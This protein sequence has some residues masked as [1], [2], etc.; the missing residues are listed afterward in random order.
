MSDF[1]A[2]TYIKDHANGAGGGFDLDGYIADHSPKPD[3]GMFHDAVK[4]TID[5]L[6]MIGGVAGGILGTPMDAVAGPMGNVVGAGIGGYAGTVAKNF[7]NKYYDPQ[8]APQNMTDVMTQ[9]LVGGATQGLA[10]GAGEA[11]APYLAKGIQAVGSPIAGAL[12][13]FA[14][15]KAVSATGATATQ[16]AKFSP[17][18]GQ[19]LLDRGLVGLGDS[20]S[21][22]AQNVSG[23]LESAGN[24][25]GSVISD[26]DKRGATVDQGDIIDA[27]RKRAQELGKDPSQY[28]V[29][30]KLNATANR[31]QTMIEA[32][33][34][35]SEVPIGMA[36]DTK[37]GF[38]ES[39]NYNSSAQDLS[40][41]KE[42]ANIYRQ[43]VEDAAT[44]FDPKAAD[45]FI[46]AKKDYKLL[47]PIEEAANKRAM[48]LNQSPHGGLMDT[49]TVIAGEGVGGIPGG[50][51]APIARRAVATR[52]ASTLAASANKA[53]NIMGAAPAVVEGA[54]PAIAQAG[55]KLVGST[56][57]P[58]LSGLE[59]LPAAA[60]NSGDVNRS[61]TGEDLWAHQGIQKLGIQDNALRSKLL[62]DPKARQLLINAS[63]LSPNSKAMKQIRDQIQKGWG[64]P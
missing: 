38:Q 33:G 57:A 22:I 24:K 62:Q 51:I 56:A 35:N 39:A 55:S 44:Q 4:S 53:G 7:I 15:K 60:Q 19:A 48:T 13:D 21:K 30:D 45:T 28:D 32:G 61:P 34:G 10:Q 20:Q 43:A 1:D 6:P 46:D 49:A 47:A 23:Q 14:A 26:L 2:D 63:D 9:P 58:G 59:A 11:V 54:V 40:H 25:V 42:A 17:D 37:K 64:K 31:L 3:S 52:I 29:A 36:E 50:I 5:S 12:K 8:S 41:A 27:L 18:A 16:A